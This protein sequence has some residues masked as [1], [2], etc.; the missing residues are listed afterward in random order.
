MFDFDM[1]MEDGGEEM[2]AQY[3]ELL[4]SPHIGARLNKY[5]WVKIWE[6]SNTFWFELKHIGNVFSFL[7]E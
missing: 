1:S 4:I 6:D 5:H 7:V 3:L 2:G